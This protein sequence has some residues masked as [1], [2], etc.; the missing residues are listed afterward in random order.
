MGGTP[1]PRPVTS[2]T[3]LPGPLATGIE[4]A[5]TSID[6]DGE[7][8][9]AARVRLHRVVETLGRQIHPEAARYV[10]A[11]LALTCASGGLGHLDEHPDLRAA[12][13]SLLR[14]TAATMRGEHDVDELEARYETA[15]AHADDLLRSGSVAPTVVYTLLACAAA[16]ATTLYDTDLDALGDGELRSDPSDW[17]ACFLGSLAASGGATWEGV[18]GDREARRRYWTWYLEVAVPHAW[19][20][21]S[22]LLDPSLPPAV[23]ARRPTTPPA[24]DG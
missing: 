11:K 22:P 21:A 5:T 23:V 18:V 15:V 19:D 4:D 17:E 7:L 13:A 24:S 8:P 20:P 2:T 1:Y 12:A 16:A 10:R 14:A 6:R 3:P 9:A